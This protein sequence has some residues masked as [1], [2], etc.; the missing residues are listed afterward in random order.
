MSAIVL[1][2][3]HLNYIWVVCIDCGLLFAT[4]DCRLEVHGTIVAGTDD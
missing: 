3:S 4:N 2:S 1:D